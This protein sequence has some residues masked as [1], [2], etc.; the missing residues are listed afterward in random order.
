[1]ASPEA[2]GGFKQEERAALPSSYVFLE[3]SAKG[4]GCSMVAVAAWESQAGTEDGTGPSTL[5]L[6][7]RAEV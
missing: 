5:E 1:M 4:K 6:A 2:G 7:D 3:A